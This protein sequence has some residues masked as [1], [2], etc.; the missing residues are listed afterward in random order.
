MKTKSKKVIKKDD[1]KATVK[2]LGK[3]YFAS[4]K[5]V[6]DVLSNLKPLG[7]VA[8]AAILTITHG[9]ITRTK[10]LSAFQSCRLFSESRLTREMAIKNQTLIFG[11][12]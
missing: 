7:K 2:I 10:I 11:D 1:Y 6:F 8:G 5:N 9:T 12:I 4:G 3:E